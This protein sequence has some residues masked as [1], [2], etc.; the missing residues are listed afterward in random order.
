MSAGGFRPSY[1]IPIAIVAAVAV[2]FLCMSGGQSHTS[3]DAGDGIAAISAGDTYYLELES[4]PTTG[5]SWSLRS[6]GGATVGEPSY[7]QHPSE[8]P[9][10][11]LGGTETFPI[12]S[13]IPGEYELAFDYVRPFGDRIPADSFVLKIR[14]V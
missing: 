9:V 11:G 13:D 8:Q 14:F 5:Y 12:T 3:S 4:N 6:D 7:K 2:A 1:F 10:C